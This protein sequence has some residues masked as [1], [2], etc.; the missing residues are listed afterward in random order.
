[1]KSFIICT[2]PQIFLGRSNQGKL[3]GRGMWLTCER[4]EKC[5]RFKRESMR[6]DLE[7]QGLDGRM[8]S[9]KIVGEL[10]GGIEWIQLA[11][12]TGP[13]VGCCEYGDE[14]SGSGATE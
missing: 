1:M 4:R 8:G 13:M 12:D 14:P 9:E 11:Q 10:A 2:N 5:I 6:E 3:G 7:D